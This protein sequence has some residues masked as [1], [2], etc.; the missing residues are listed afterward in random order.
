MNFIKIKIISLFFLCLV[1]VNS[2]NESFVYLDPNET[3]ENRVSDLMSKMTLEEKVYQMNQFVGLEHMRQAE[4]DLTDALE[5]N[6][7]DPYVLN[8][9]AYSWL[10]RNL[11]LDKALNLC[12]ASNEKK[13]AHLI[14]NIKGAILFRQQNYELAKNE[15]LKSIDLDEKFLDPHKN[16]FNLNIKLKDYKSAIVNIKNVI[17]LESTKIIERPLLL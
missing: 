7:N 15:F 11:N 16:L 2:Q 8:Y 3:V 5:I 4:K 9:L 1:K 17:K 12:E 6:P 14:T 13:I 10:D